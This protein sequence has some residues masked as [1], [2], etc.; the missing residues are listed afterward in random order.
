M[1]LNGQGNISKNKKYGLMEGKGHNQFEPKQNIT[2][3][4]FAALLVRLLKLEES[5]KPNKCLLM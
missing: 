3:A 4:E 5:N 2:R 1:P